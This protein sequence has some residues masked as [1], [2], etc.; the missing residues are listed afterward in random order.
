MAIKYTKKKLLTRPVISMKSEGAEC[1]IKIQSPFHEGK[2]RED[3]KAGDDKRKKSTLVLDVVNLETGEEAQLVAATM[4]VSTL[5]EEY[6]DD[7]YVG[8]CFHL[9]NTGKK[10]GAGGQRYNKMLIEEIEP[11]DVADED[12]TDGKKKRK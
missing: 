2:M 10:E 1:F 11:S 12:E 4:L 5:T 3:D 9:V 7:S 8:L 6:P